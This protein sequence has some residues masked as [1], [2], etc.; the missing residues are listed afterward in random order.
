MISSE[1]FARLA[2]SLRRVRDSE[3]TDA[4]VVGWLRGAV[5]LARALPAP[6]TIPSDR[7]YTRTLLHR[8]D[9]FEVLVL[10]WMPNG[11]STIHDHGGSQCWFAVASG[12][13]GVENYARRDR[14][15]T[16]GYARIAL[17]GRQELVAGCID[18][19]GDDEHLHRCIARDD[20]V[21][22]LHV[23]AA[24]LKRY[25]TFDERA[26]TCSPE[27]ASYDAIFEGALPALR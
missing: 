6:A 20:L 13:M 23:Y 8:S 17:Q 21:T 12:T 14:G 11:A 22:T 7:Q 4:R 2:A 15:D 19:R 10:H 5:S 1:P 16:G 9:L 3:E 18:Y 24:P 27:I 26:Q 25:Y